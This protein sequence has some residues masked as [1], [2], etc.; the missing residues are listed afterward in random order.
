M[1]LRFRAGLLLIAL[2]L[3][4]F[5]T[6]SA[7]EK[8]ST[9]SEKIK[10]AYNLIKAYHSGA[11][12][13]SNVVKLVY[14]HGKDL[15][16]LSNWKERLTSTLDSV[17]NFYKE[18]FFRY[19]ISIEGVPFEK[20][21]GEYVFHVVEGDSIS[22]KYS[23]K[24]GEKIL[25]EIYTKTKSQI[26]FSKEFILVINGLCYKRDD[27]TYVFHS[28][29]FGIGSSAFGACL[30]A[31]CELLDSKL[32]KNT[33]QRMKFSEMMINL[34]ECSVAEF[35][36][37]YVGG[38]AHEMGHIFGLPHDFGSPK[39]VDNST[40]SLMGQYGSRHFKDYLWG[41]N[42]S[43]IFSS[44]SILQL[45]SH[46]VFTQSNKNRNQKPKVALS[47]LRFDQNSEG[48]TLK[49][50]MKGDQLPY[51]VVSL[52]RPAKLT[53]Y[54]NLSFSNVITG[55]DSIRLEYGHW[56][57]GKYKLQLLILYPNGAVQ[58]INKE[59]NVDN[60]GKAEVI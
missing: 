17:S 53:E 25:Q 33:T 48:I 21:G 59:M 46:P 42:K 16:P 11:E 30:V 51:G 32:L 22:R 58:N 45:M 49:A 5:Q 9:D 50:A 19:G 20:R 28:P 41:G 26:D 57:E 55:A 24:S 8:L 44:A 39:L 54:F 36:S 18:E 40:I 47:N 27:D 37:W 34:K 60:R 1:K 10:K 43:A 4:D 56:A 31:D 12:H 2:S 29:Y 38:I 15:E 3:L 14:F 7:Q 13:E 23:I 6:L 52:I 35:N